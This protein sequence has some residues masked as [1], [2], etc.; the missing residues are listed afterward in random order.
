MKKSIS[1]LLIV[2]A[3]SF[4]FAQK[5]KTLFWEISGN[6]LAKKSYIYGTMHVNDKVSYH[7]SDAFFKNLLNAD[8]VSN[9][10]DPETWDEID[11][12][13]KA[14]KFSNQDKFYKSFYLK[15][16]EKNNIKSLFVNT[17]FF[18]NLLSG[19][20]G[21]QSDYQ[22]DTVLDSFIYQ[23]G[24]KYKKKIVGLESATES[25]L[26][27]MRVQSDDAEPNEKNREVLMK[28][29]KNG[30]FPETLKD[31]YRE[32]DIVMLDSIYRL[33]M[34]Q[35]A[36]D[37]LIVN[38]NVVMAKSIDSLSR[39]GSLFAAVGAAHL[40][41]KMGIIQ[42]LKDKGY[43]LTPIF[44]AIT[45]VGTKQKKE[46]EQFFPNPGF[47]IVSTNDQMI[48]IPLTSKI[49]KDDE[50]IGSPDF[51]NG[52]AINVKRL[53]LNN[54]LN[55]KNEVFNHK[56]LDS[57][58]F[59]NIPGTIENKK[60]YKEELAD[61]YDI[62]NKTKNGNFQHWRFYITP[63]E[64]ISIS[65]TGN[66]LYTNQFESEVFNP[67]QLKKANSNWETISIN[68]SNFNI[69]LPS[70]NLIYG[71]SDDDIR[72]IEIQAFEPADNS[73][74]FLTERTLNDVDFLE[75][76]AFENHQIHYEFYLQHDAKIESE[77]FD[78]DNNSMISS[79]TIGNQRIFLK[80][81][82]KG[83]KYYLLGAVNSND[84]KKSKF[85]DSFQ[86][87]TTKNIESTTVYTD[88][89]LNFKIAVPK[90]YNEKLFLNLPEN[91][92]K[93]K[94]VFESDIKHFKFFSANGSAVK[95]DLLKYHKYYTIESIDSLKINLRKEFLN[96]YDNDQAAIEKV[97]FNDDYDDYDYDSSSLSLLDQ[98]VY[99]KKGF[100]FTTWYKIMNSKD[101][102]EIISES[103]S[104]DTEKK[105]HVFEALVV[106]NSSSQAVKHTVYFNEESISKFSALVD[107]NYNKDNQFIENVIHSFSFIEPNKNSVFKDNWKHFVEDAS[108][109][110]DTIRY[111]AMNS[112]YL[113]KLKKQ[114]IDEVIG[115]IDT[116]DFKDDET[117]SVEQLIAQLGYI[118]DPRVIPYLENKYKQE[119]VKTAIQ[120][121]VL[122][123]LSNQHSKSGYQKIIEL[124]EYDLPISDNQYEISSLFK[125]FE[126]DL[127]NS[128]VLYPK[129]FQFYSIKEYNIPV[130]DFCNKLIDENKASINKLKSYKKIIQT[131]AKLEYKRVLSW[132]EKNPSE[133]DQSDFSSIIQNSIQSVTPIKDSVSVIS[134]DDDEY[135]EPSYLSADDLIA[136]MNLIS[137][138]SKEPS[139]IVL[140]DKIAKL[141]I[142]ILTLELI[143][144]G[145]IHDDITDEK[146][147]LLL[148]SN[149]FKFATI[150]LLLNQNKN[151]LISSITDQEIAKSSIYSFEEIAKKDKLTFI[152]QKQ[153]VVNGIETQFFFY[154][155]TVKGDKKTSDK[156]KLCSVAF[157]SNQSKIDPQAYRY[158]YSILIDEQ[159]IEEEI[160][161]VL[162]KFENEQ[163]I[164]ASFEKEEDANT[165][166]YYPMY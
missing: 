69:A 1:F 29:I 63:L 154:E 68:K 132:K 45:E 15:S 140:F 155:L 145:V 74:Y 141:K 150:Q 105:C 159:P 39:T 56:T 43:T 73:Y 67:I 50:N 8:I 103:S 166:P 53:L 40:S 107:K 138:F 62:K 148:M 156:Q 126:N 78:A 120:L 90:K 36:H 66:S 79:S 115:F 92:Y 136:Y 124:L 97:S 164:R 139:K 157:V 76:T 38:R 110:Q 99:N 10:S 59:E 55:K 52:G 44:D 35:K 42:L 94:N 98:G 84:E 142:P 134:S 22:E 24:R 71:N 101:N 137:H 153:V 83:D 121:S 21:I 72:N 57:L 61:V 34:S 111:S 133:D 25:T 65:M 23:T 41:G 14:P 82:I 28:I 143:R 113:L 5:E 163:H 26:N 77:T 119:G 17:N 86:F 31:L 47:K 46:I 16:I 160:N 100:Q 58:F 18:T 49:I 13:L 151:N 131:N 27:I 129:I 48:S 70:Y 87:S 114:D 128:K 89:T 147:Q 7:L 91:T 149:D 144:L 81:I 4:V 85:F 32:K 135:L 2:C 102:Y 123:A 122:R 64:I 146:L 93:D 75:S 118:N 125:L 12:L 112:V 19:V 106:K 33:M 6:G 130:L 109:E 127:E 96:E 80:S 3:C 158:F 117:E 95:M 30:N 54:F 108:S 51:T 152:N 104:F 165:A 37:V 162:L 60:F 88:K 161:K 116:Y 9:E 11:L 20:D